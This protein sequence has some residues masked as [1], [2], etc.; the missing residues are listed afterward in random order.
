MV[1]LSKKGS[2]IED[3]VYCWVVKDWRSWKLGFEREL[4]NV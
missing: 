2:L 1:S 3:N 4:G